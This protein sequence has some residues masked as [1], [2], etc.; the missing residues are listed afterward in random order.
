MLVENAIKHNIVSNAKPLQI[1]IYIENDKYISVRNNLQRK[2]EGVNSLKTGLENIK[3][4]YKHLSDEPVT[5]I[6]T[7]DSFKVSLPLIELGYE[8][9]TLAS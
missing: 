8:A 3:Q 9:Q 6:E 2:T 1:D 4:R 5:V 7:T